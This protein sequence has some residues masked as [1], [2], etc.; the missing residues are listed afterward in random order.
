[1]HAEQPV[2]AAS[3]RHVELWHSRL[4]VAGADGAPDERV[5]RKPGRA[6]DLDP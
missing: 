2:D 3:G 4:A 1:M 5:S 6:G